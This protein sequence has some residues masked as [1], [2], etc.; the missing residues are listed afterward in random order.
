MRYAA[1]LLSVMA[2]QQHATVPLRHS[3]MLEMI[4][5]WNLPVNALAE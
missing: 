1:E 4:A 2:R 3:V 5:A